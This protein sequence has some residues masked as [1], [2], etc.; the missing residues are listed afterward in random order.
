MSVQEIEKIIYILDSFGVGVALTATVGFLIVKFFYPAYLKQKGKNLATKEDV[1]EITGKIESIKA[2]YTKDIERYKS[3]IH[4]SQDKKKKY[5]DRKIELFLEFYDHV[6][7]FRYESLVVEFGN[8][9]SDEGKALFEYNEKFNNSVV[10]IMK[11]YQRLV[12]YTP[13]GEQILY[14]AE[15]LTYSVLGARE[16]LGKRFFPLKI[17]LIKEREAMVSGVREDIEE[18]VKLSDKASSEFWG[19]MNPN[20]DCFTDYYQKFISDLNEFVKPD[21]KA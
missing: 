7:E 18:T 11:C 17:A 14:H 2:L 20:I 15:Q 8:F 6:T 19:D 4:L 21:E 10:E 1:E 16:V 12:V 9:P 3:D 13:P 5:S